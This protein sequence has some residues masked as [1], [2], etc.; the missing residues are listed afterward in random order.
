MSE[1]LVRLLIFVALATLLA[2]AE[3]RWPRHRA[4][5]NRARRWPVNLGLGLL[6]TVCL[7]LLAPVLA[8]V[9]AIWARQHGVG[10][11]NLLSVPAWLA[12]AVSMLLLDMAIYWQHRILH[13]VGWLWRLHRVHHTDVALDVSSGL[14]FHPMEIVLSLGVKVAVVLALGA[15]PV[16]VLAFEILLSSFS[17]FTHTN[18]AIP[19]R[20]DRPLRWLIVTPDMHRIHHSVLREE[21]DSN[22]GFN[23]SWWDRLFGSYRDQP[24]QPQ[25]ELRL[26]L[27]QFRQA[28][29]QR[30]PALL[31]QPFARQ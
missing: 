23:A 8:Y 6:N 28:S 5:A 22:F 31:M 26:G 15:P 20:A 10:M 9:M 19:V 27:E 12:V 29:E 13:R 16:A 30:F 18:L 24:R 4:P 1:A 17:L 14:R 25:A 21:H 2:L 3:W 11:F 7:R